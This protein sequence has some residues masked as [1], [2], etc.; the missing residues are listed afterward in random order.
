MCSIQPPAAGRLTACGVCGAQEQERKERLRKQREEKEGAAKPKAAPPAAAAAAAAGGASSSDPPPV[1][2]C[3]ITEIEDGAAEASGSGPADK[4]AD[5]P[6]VITNEGAGFFFSRGPSCHCGSTEL[7]G[8]CC[9]PVHAALRF[10]DGALC[11]ARCASSF[12]QTTA[13]KRRRTRGS[14]S[15]MRRVPARPSTLP[16]R[17]H[18]P[19]CPGLPEA[20]RRGLQ[21]LILL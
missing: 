17:T 13:A 19:T 3:T 7:C 6:T 4:G 16:S 18:T 5:G 21:R 15:P 14:R 9:T 10:T 12:V 2:R 8:R 11:F 20:C 1:G